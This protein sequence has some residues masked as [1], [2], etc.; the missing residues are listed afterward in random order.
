L[1][2]TSGA[3]VAEVLNYGAIKH[4]V[5]GSSGT[6][7][8]DTF[9]A[10]HSNSLWRNSAGQG[11]FML[12]IAEHEIAVAFVLASTGA[13]TWV[14]TVSAEENQPISLSFRYG[15]A[16][17]G[18][19]HPR[20]ASGLQVERQA[21]AAMAYRESLNLQAT[22]LPQLGGIIEWGGA[23]P[24]AADVTEYPI[25]RNC[26][27]RIGSD[28][29]EFWVWNAPRQEWDLMM[30]KTYSAYS[31]YNGS[32]PQ[33]AQP[34]LSPTSGSTVAVTVAHTDPD[35]EYYASLN[36]AAYELVD[37]SVFGNKFILPHNEND[38][39]LLLAVYARKTG[40]Q[41]SPIIYGQYWLNT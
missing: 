27:V 16:W 10:T 5:M 2:I 37:L 20:T 12:E 35:V 14:T 13:V 34:T 36:W 28:P 23:L 17:S 7:T 8:L 30:A 11:F 38:D 9:G 24:T 3:K 26:I 22:Y 15:R 40:F 31:Y 21:V 29:A 25:L 19:R 6:G 41:D 1:L 18:L 32:R 39:P 4:L 33:L